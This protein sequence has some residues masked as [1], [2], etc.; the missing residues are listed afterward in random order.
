MINEDF[1]VDGSPIF[2]YLGGEWKIEPDTITS[3]LWV[4]IAKQHNGSVVYTEHRFFGESIPIKY[5]I[6]T[7]ISWRKI[8][9]F[10]QISQTSINGEP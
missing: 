8:Y 6:P 1:F 7:T 3:G 9:I 4:D 2:I 5:V 10:I